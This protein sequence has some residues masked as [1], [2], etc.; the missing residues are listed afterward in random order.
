[1]T[2]IQTSC[3]S[4]ANCDDFLVCVQSS[5]NVNGTCQTACSLTSNAQPCPLGNQCETLP[6]PSTMQIGYCPEPTACSGFAGI[7]CSGDRN[8][9][10]VDDP[11]DDCDPSNGDADCGGICVREGS[12][13]SEPCPVGYHRVDNSKDTCNPAQGGV[14]CPGP[15]V[16]DRLCDGRGLEPCF[17]GETCVHDPSTS[18]AGAQECPGICMNMAAKVCALVD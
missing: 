11:R 9:N 2:Q 3:R 16:Q 10:C 12:V 4:D 8:P 13:S 1:M 17:E 18:C 14:D 15:C 7:A 6:G 5:E